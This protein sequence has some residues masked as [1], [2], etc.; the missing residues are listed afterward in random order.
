MSQTAR[1]LTGL[2]AGI[3]IGVWLAWFDQPLA[4]QVADIVSPF[5]KLWLNALQMTIVP[6]VVSLIIAGIAGAAA[7]AR[8]NGRPEVA[9]AR[10]R[11]LLAV[12]PGADEARPE[13]AEAARV[14]GRRR[15]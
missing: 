2:V 5:G 1:V 12:A 6:L 13:L 14:L 8:A 11:L 7:A 3:V 9:A 15:D 4:L 10:Y